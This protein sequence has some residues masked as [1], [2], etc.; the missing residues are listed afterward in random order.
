MLVFMYVIHDMHLGIIT[1]SKNR[2]DASTNV[3]DRNEKFINLYKVSVEALRNKLKFTH[4]IK[5]LLLLHDIMKN[6]YITIKCLLSFYVV[7][8]KGNTKFISV[9][10]YR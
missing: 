9:C 3:S 10:W 6:N 4:E 8:Y 1:H 5:Y 7:V 2:S